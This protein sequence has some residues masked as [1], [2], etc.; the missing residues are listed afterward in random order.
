MGNR[1][2]YLVHVA[3]NRKPLYTTAFNSRTEL[4]T[5][6]RRQG[7]KFRNDV[8]SNIGESSITLHCND[9]FSYEIEE[10]IDQKR[11]LIF[12]GGEYVPLKDYIEETGESKR[13][14]EYAFKHKKIKGLTVG[15]KNLIYIYRGEAQ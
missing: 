4:V 15:K 12:E 13:T 11:S 3:Q 9:S 5:Y 6:L 8:V 14:I 10:Q 7:L 2:K 1:K